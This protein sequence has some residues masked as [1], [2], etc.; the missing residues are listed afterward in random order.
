MTRVV[1][2]LRKRKAN[3]G[4]PRL[5]LPDLEKIKS[6]FKDKGSILFF[7]LSLF[8]GLFFGS[9]VVNSLSER[10]LNSLDFLFMT[11]LPEKIKGG[12]S[13]AFFADFASNFL[14]LS[15]AVF[16]SLSLFGGAFL[17]LTALFK[18]FGI[19]VSAAYLIGNYGLKGAFFYFCVILPGIFA[20]TLILVYELSAG[21]SVYKKFVLNIFRDKNYPLKGAVSVFLKKSLKNLLWTLAVSAADAGLW[22]LFAGLFFSNR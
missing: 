9:A 7:L 4:L 22:F 13:E 20:F 21:F 5:R 16:F 14:F 19:G 18:G 15:A 8:S 12:I 2:T 11:N 10:T 6:F 3:R 1:F 17:P